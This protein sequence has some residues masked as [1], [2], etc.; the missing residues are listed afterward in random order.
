M[1]R[2]LS[3]FVMLGTSCRKTLQSREV[4]GGWTDLR[5]Q[6]LGRLKQKDSCEVKAG[7]YYIVTSRLARTTQRDPASNRQHIWVVS[8]SDHGPDR[9][10]KIINVCVN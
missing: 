3:K 4:P 7:L 10:T 5:S 2:K 1:V 9:V 6:Q 8:D